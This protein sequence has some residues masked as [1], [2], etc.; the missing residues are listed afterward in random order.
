[1][2]YAILASAECLFCHVYA[3]NHIDVNVEKI[4]DFNGLHPI[5]TQLNKS[6]T[7]RAQLGTIEG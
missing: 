1:M 7:L 5:R 4:T 6:S 2:W 3:N